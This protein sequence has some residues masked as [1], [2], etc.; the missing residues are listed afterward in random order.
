VPALFKEFTTEAGIDF[1]VYLEA[2]PG[3]NLDFH[4]REKAGIIAKAWDYVVLQGHSLLD[5]KNPGDPSLLRRSAKSLAQ[6]LTDKNPNVHM[7]FVSTWT[8]ADQTYPDSGYWHGKPFSQMALDIR[9]GY[10]LASA[11]CAP[12]ASDVVPVG[13]AWNRAMTEGVADPNPYDGISAGQIDLW[14]YDH[15]HASAYGY[16]LSALMIFGD[17][18]GLDPRS[19]G[20]RERAAYELGFSAGQ[21]SAL[22]QIAFEELSVT[23]AGTALRPFTVRVEGRE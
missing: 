3:K 18:T 6:L 19:L 21:A 4:A 17:I 22:Q 5:I 9:K 16:Y 8:R 14:T 20:G 15:Y 10:D 12:V 13:E 11:D 23:H 7:Q 1:T 2:F